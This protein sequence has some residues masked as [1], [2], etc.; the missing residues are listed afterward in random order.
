[1]ELFLRV[2]RFNL[3]FSKVSGEKL[4]LDKAFKIINQSIALLFVIAKIH[5]SKSGENYQ[6]CKDK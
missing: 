3:W 1:M 4:L 6:A 2:P 5:Q